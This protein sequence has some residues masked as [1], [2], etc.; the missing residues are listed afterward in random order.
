MLLSRTTFMK[1]VDDVGCKLESKLALK[2]QNWSQT[3]TGSLISNTRHPFRTPSPNR[4]WQCWLFIYSWGCEHRENGYRLVIGSID[5]A[6]GDI[7][8]VQLPGIGYCAGL[9]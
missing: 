1:Y 3:V 9:G 5:N 7:R 2:K 6:V 4:A 8:K